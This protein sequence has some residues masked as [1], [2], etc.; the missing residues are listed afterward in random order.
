MAGA[1]LPWVF[2]QKH[3]IMNIFEKDKN[4]K[5]KEENEIERNDKG[6]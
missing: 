1:L 5:S 3:N 6:E 2:R 4:I